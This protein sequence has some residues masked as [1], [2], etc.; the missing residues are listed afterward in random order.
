MVGANGCV[1]CMLKSNCND[2]RCGRSCPDDIKYV[3]AI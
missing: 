1:D 3:Q 2:V